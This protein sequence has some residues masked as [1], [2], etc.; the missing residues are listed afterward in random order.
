[1]ALQVPL[2]SGTYAGEPFNYGI[3]TVFDH[4]MLN[5]QGA[6]QIYACSNRTY[7]GDANVIGF[8]G[9][10][11]NDLEEQ[12]QG[13]DPG[14]TNAFV[15]QFYVNGNYTYGSPQYLEYENHPGIDYNAPFGTEALAAVGGIVSYPTAGVVGLG[16]HTAEFNVLELD[17]IGDPAHKVYY[18]HLSTNPRTISVCFGSQATCLLQNASGEDFVACQGST[19]SPPQC[20]GSS[21]Q[22]ARKLESPT[23]PAQRY[24]ISGQIQGLSGVTATV[25]YEGR[26]ASGACVANH[27]LTA[28]D[29][30]YVISNLPQGWY[31]VRP[32]LTGYSFA[33]KNSNTSFVC[34]GS[35]SAG[36]VI[37]LSGNASIPGSCLGPHLHFEVQ[38]KTNRAQRNIGISQAYIPIDPYGWDGLPEDRYLEIAGVSSA[39]LWSETPAVNAISPASASVGTTILLTG[40]GLNAATQVCFVLST[41]ASSKTCQSVIGSPTQILT[42]IPGTLIQGNYFVSVQDASSNRSDSKVLTVN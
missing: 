35:V 13:C 2:P 8:S 33:F 12:N 4:S 27:V 21:A 18:L 30:S 11:G 37:A 20:S 3:N 41:D 17:P 29:G 32:S 19:C 14:Y 15:P 1:M 36:Q 16:G 42:S 39:R 10:V 9:E 28:P 34:P 7:N 25:S 26:T 24:Q 6:Y 38:Q 40:V 5:G 23:K 31:T 22:S